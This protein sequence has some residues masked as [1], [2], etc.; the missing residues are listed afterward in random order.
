MKKLFF[1]KSMFAK[2]M[3]SFILVI[4][5]VSSFYMYSYK[6]F[7]DIVENQIA[8]NI[9]ERFDNVIARFDR[10]FEQIKYILLQMSFE[11]S[12]NP[13]SSGNKLSPYE[14]IKV[15]ESFMQRI[16]KNNQNEYLQDVRTI[17]I[18]TAAEDEYIIESH[19][20]FQKDDFFHLFY[21]NPSYTEEF[22]MK[23]LKKDFTFNIYPSALY[24]NRSIQ[25]KESFLMPVAFKLK[26]NNNYMVVALVDIRQIA[27]NIEGNAIDSLY[28]Y[29]QEGECLFPQ[30]SGLN[31]S[32][33]DFSKNSRFQKTQQ[34]YLFT[35][36]SNSSKLRYYKLVSDTNL[37]REV[38]K[39]RAIFQIVLVVAILI[40]VII[41]LIIVT[42]FNNPVKQISE[43]IKNSKNP[44]S[45]EDNTA[46]LVNIKDNI[47][48]LVHMNEDYVQDI[49]SKN[50]MLK[51]F[52]YQ[53]RIQDV[54]YNL[55]DI[56]DIFS[57]N[58][59]YALAHFQVHYREAFDEKIS[60]EKSK[61]TFILKELIDL[62]ISS[63]F[64]GSITFQ[65]ENCKVVS[66]INIDKVKHD[67]IDIMQDISN[68]LQ[69]ED[70]FAFFTIAISDIND[71]VSN[72]QKVYN[73]L[74]HV[75]RSRKPLSGTQLLTKQLIASYPKRFF[76][77]QEHLETLRK[78]L[79]NGLK[80]ECTKLVD[81][82]LYFNYRKNVNCFYM[83][84]LCGEVINCCIHELQKL[85]LEVPDSLNTQDTIS[86][87]DRSV[88][89]EDF[90][91]L[92]CEVIEKF[93]EC[94]VNSKKEDDYILDFITKYVE[95]HYHEDI[96][97]DI[98]ADRLGLTPTY[99][100]TYFK[101]K[102]SINLMEYVNCYKI[103]KAV[104]L[105][106]DSKLKVKDIALKVGIS[107]INTFIRLF[108]KYEGNTP[109][110][111]RKQRQSILETRN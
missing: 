21:N 33:L 43:I 47:Q 63:S 99:V 45:E 81:D 18:V 66:V 59:K 72:I 9:D 90:Q 6:A 27:S 86:R 44:F 38:S 15:I 108:K 77:S 78:T 35:R 48:R 75:A 16:Y 67:F 92:C 42:K 34:G 71:D 60:E 8:Q 10:Y 102:M 56:K 3:A 30:E 100:S 2:L 88:T 52:F 14:Q 51:S 80:E 25:E 32:G 55:N 62:Y 101:D 57:I 95:E 93:V 40:S 20:T 97:L 104:E 29:S 106:E 96:Y 70:E 73:Q 83:G 26:D 109:N 50:S 39:V 98:F 53:A 79:V 24:K 110:E 7:I 76:L 17:F 61:A 74:Y 103:K 107:N 4:F 89:L 82:I 22:W 36:T 94:I 28:I 23:E 49:S 46:D 87:L 12:F 1:L 54:Y 65:V 111:Y 85:Q 19:G 68:K 37:K 13:L 64:P 105:M 11:S 84:L 58:H 69:A 5:V 41:S 91:K 31:I